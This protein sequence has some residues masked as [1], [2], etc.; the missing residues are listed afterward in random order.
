MKNHWPL[1]LGV[2]V[3]AL[4]LLAVLGVAFLPR[5][6]AGPS[7]DILLTGGNGYYPSGDYVDKIENGRLARRPN[8]EA[9]L[10]WRYDGGTS[11]QVRREPDPA[12]APKL[13]RYGIA[14]GSLKELSLEEA[15]RLSLDAGPTSD[16]GFSV[17]QTGYIDSGIFELF[18]SRG[19]RAG[20]LPVYRDGKVVDE[21][22]LPTS[23]GYYYGGLAFLAWIK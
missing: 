2:G 23:S 11:Y 16:D 12:R 1:I 6:G 13:Y 14:D 8:E 9:L 15:T 7:H 22:V 20:Q 19:S 4:F 18:G 5:L 3:P 21:L 17:G 10:E